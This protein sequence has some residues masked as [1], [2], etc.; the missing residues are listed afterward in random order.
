MF[1]VKSVEG[2]VRESGIWITYFSGVFYLGFTFLYVTIHRKI[3][4]KFRSTCVYLFGFVTLTHVIIQFIYPKLLIQTFSESLCLLILY[5]G[6]EKPED[7]IDSQLG[8]YKK[9]A[10]VNTAKMY[11]EED[12]PFTVISVTIDDKEYLEKT[13]GIEVMNNFESVL[14]EYLKKVAKKCN[15]LKLRT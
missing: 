10:F 7:L 12:I 13:F 4:S 6:V 14:A 9:M 1:S 2:Y 15:I 8:V 11:F 3:I 5:L